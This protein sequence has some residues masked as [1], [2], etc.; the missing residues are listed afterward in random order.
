MPRRDVQMLTP[1][2]RGPAGALNALM[3]DALTP[4]GTDRPENAAAD[5][6]SGSGTRSLRSGGLPDRGEPP[7][8]PGSCTTCGSAAET[9]PPGERN[10]AG[11]YFFSYRRGR[12]SV[13]G[14]YHAD[15]GQP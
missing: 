10:A 7:P 12:R 11:T 5:G 8:A 15:V 14:L 3:H 6:A 9:L 13:L 4:A 1:M 2:H